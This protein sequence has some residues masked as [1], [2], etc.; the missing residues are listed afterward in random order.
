MKFKIGDIVKINK[1]SIVNYKSVGNFVVV[2]I[3]VY[4][5]LIGVKVMKNIYYCYDEELTKVNVKKRPIYM[6]EL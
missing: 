6:E 1:D 2:I 4:Q 5:D 3:S